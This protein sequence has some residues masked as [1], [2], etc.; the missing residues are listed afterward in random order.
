VSPIWTDPHALATIGITLAAFVLFATEKLPVQ[1]TALLTVVALMLVFG[2]VP[3]AAELPPVDARGFLLGFGHEGL[4]TV[5]ALMVLGR[6]I[7]VTGAF[8]PVARLLSRFWAI[9][10]QTAFLLLLVVC[11]GFSTVFNDTPI[12]VLMLPLLLS[13][14]ARTGTTAKRTLMP[15]NFAVILGGMGTTIGTSTNL[16]INGIAADLG[17]PPFALF[18]FLPMVAVAAAIALPY[19]WLVMPRLLPQG[20]GPGRAP[21]E[22]AFDAV[23]VIGPGAWCR[24]RTLRTVIRRT[25]SLR[26]RRIEREGLRLMRRGALELAAGDRLCVSGTPA[27]LRESAALLGA[28]I[29]GPV[30]SSRAASR[31][32][33]HLAQIIITEESALAGTSLMASDFAIQQGLLVL[34]MHRPATGLIEPLSPAVSTLRPGDVLLLQATEPQIE[35]LRHEPG[36]ITLD[37]THRLPRS[38]HAIVAV[39]IMAGVIALAATGTLPMV[40]AALAGLAAMMIAG[41]LQWRDIGDAISSKVVLIIVA[42]L[43]LGRGLMETGVIGEIG[44]SFAHVTRGLEPA[45][46]MMLLMLLFGILTNFVSN[47]AAGVLGT[48]IA[49]E[50][51]RLLGADPQPFVLAVLFG[52]NLCFA[53]PMGYQ[54]NLLVMSA[55]GYRFGDFLRAGGPLFVLVWLT[56]SLLIAR[57]YGLG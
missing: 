56:L 49:V 9:A 27:V 36:L 55:A 47:N 54:T 24:G 53:T 6:G 33:Q 8:D 57:N 1:T 30:P 35:A 34:G 14:A 32:D 19:L 45:T 40:I 20:D 5:V 4:V 52:C 23:F 51:A 2:L 38:S 37:G 48:P 39:L 41:A 7:E 17:V 29:E 3:R 25:K 50:V 46:V 44:Q 11:L 15:M 13:I 26:I 10:P 43:A 28:A 21:R 16:L 18:E 31:D 42:S 12:V 22:R